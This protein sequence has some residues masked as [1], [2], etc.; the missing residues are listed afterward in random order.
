[1]QA[2]REILAVFKTDTRP[3][4][5]GL[6]EGNKAV[7]GLK[8]TLKS[9]AGP[10]LAAF[11]GAAV[12]SFTRD[13]IAGAD[14]TAKMAD[15]LGLGIVE[16]QGW[17]HAA[18]LSSVETEL[19]RAT[20]SKLQLQLNEVATKGT[21]PAAESLKVLG[22]EATH[23]AGALRPTEQVLRDVTSALSGLD[24]AEQKAELVKLFG[25]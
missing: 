20:F 15:S 19:L 4:K 22:I 11:S 25:E 12:V 21:G 6:A 13:L 2:L 8:N 1:M 7:D 18:D 16:L 14:A 24:E 23:A 3:L 5:K 9:L 10:L 17:K